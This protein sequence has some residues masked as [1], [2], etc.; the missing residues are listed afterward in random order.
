M[1]VYHDKNI[2]G[3]GTP[4]TKLT[5]LPVNRSFIWDKQEILI[6]TVYVSKAGAAL[7][8]CAKLDTDDPGSREFAVEICL[9]DTPL[10]RCMSSSM[11]WYPNNIIQMGNAVPASEDR[12]ENNKFSEEWIDAYGCDREC[13]WYFER[14]CYD[15]NGEPI[16]SPQKISLAFR[17]NLISITAGHFSTGVS[18]LH[19]EP[20]P[21]VQWHVIFQVKPKD[22]VET[23]FPIET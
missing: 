14:L 15:W 11:R 22:D 9:D 7:D 2:W 8:V 4:E 12:F 20:V 3:K 10:L 16:L 1:D 23:S 6:P 18:S 13:C 21:E 5:P 17:A 19:F